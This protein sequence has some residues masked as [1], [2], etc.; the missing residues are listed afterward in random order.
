MLPENE[1][2]PFWWEVWL[3][4]KGDRQAVLHDFRLFATSTLCTA[5]EHSVEFPE[6]TVTW[7]YGSQAMFSAS[8]MML[9]CVAELKRAKDTATFFTNM[10]MVEQRLW[11]DDL[12]V[13]FTAPEE[14]DAVPHV[15]L[16]DTGVNRAHP[17]LAPILSEG[18]M[19]TINADW[20]TDDRGNHGTGMAGLALYGDLTEVLSSEHPVTLYHRLESVKLTTGQ[21]GNMGDDKQ[22]AYLFG[23]A[24]SRPEI[25]NGARRRVFSSAVTSTYYRNYGRPSAWSS[26]VDRLAVDADAD[27]PLPRLFVLS[28]GNIFNDQHWLLYPDGQALNQIHDPGQ[29]WNALT[30]GAFTRKV[31]LT[32]G[33]FKAIAAEGG[34]SPFST[35]S[36]GW[37][38][39][40]PLKPDVV[41][42]GG[43]AATDGVEASNFAELELLTTARDP[44]RRLYW[45]TNATSA[46]SA[47]CARMAADL[48]ALYPEY[49]PETI[50]ALITHSARWTPEMLRMFPANSQTGFVNLIRHCGWGVPDPDLARWSVNNSLTLVEESRLK[51]YS[52]TKDRVKTED[53]NLHALPWP[54]EALEALQNTQVE[55]RVTLSYFIEPNPSA[56]GQKSRFHYPSH[57]LRFAMKR[58]LERYEDFITRINAAS[59]ADGERY[60][61]NDDNWALGMLQRHR[62]SL[63][64]DIWT[65]TAAELASCGYLAVY[66]GQG[67]WRSRQGLNRFDSE[68]PYSL[69]ISIHAPGTEVD[70]LTP[71]ETLVDALIG[72]TVRIPS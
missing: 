33:N 8:A 62:G 52:K 3:P 51:P 31:E 35:T 25:F 18:D 65:G 11:A 40:W 37:D 1:R 46:A 13:N 34:L 20:G 5:S 9:N 15:C 17:L 44:L 16:L 23:E 28:A 2:E 10:P 54:V 70:L 48:M 55:M 45:T 26:V 71:V 72:T 30:V 6:R 69:V 41:F 12:I 29:S 49:R 58:P 14:G 21:D 68:A 61:G 67:W 32:Y 19:H 42:E 59:E 7:M 43:N 24:V 36:S 50:R 64:Q 39:E 56:R 38:R 63:H 66:P 47:L 4:V 27:K 22:H 53:M 57:R 60:A